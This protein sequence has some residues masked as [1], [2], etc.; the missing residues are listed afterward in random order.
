MSLVNAL[1]ELSELHVATA[2]KFEELAKLMTTT[3]VTAE[4]APEPVAEPEPRPVLARKRPR[5][6]VVK[7]RHYR[8]ALLVLA[9]RKITAKGVH[10]RLC[11]NNGVNFSPEVLSRTLTGVRSTLNAIEDAGYKL[12]KK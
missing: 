7:D 3:P 10:A 12:V 5:R 9:D 8:T 2:L 11:K 4:P 6:H 1:S